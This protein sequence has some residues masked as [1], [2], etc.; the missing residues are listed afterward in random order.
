MQTLSILLSGVAFWALVIGLISPKAFNWMFKG[1]SNR[2]KLGLVFGIPAVVFFVLFFIFSIGTP[3]IATAK[4]PTNKKDITI[5]GTSA[6]DNSKMEVFQNG[7]L[8]KEITADNDGRFSS[9]IELVE[10]SNKIK[11]TSTNEKG[12]TQTSSETEIVLDITPPDLSVEQPQSPTENEKVTIKGKSEKYAKIIVSLGGKE[13]K[14]T[15]VRKDSFEIKNIPLAEGENKFIV[16]AIDQADNY[17]EPKEIVMVYNKPVVKE[18]T[19]TETTNQT[20][21]PPKETAQQTE[22]PKEEAKPTET[23]KVESKTTQQLDIDK[24]NELVK[25]VGS[26]ETTILD[27]SSNYATAQSQPPYQ[28][29]V[30]T[31]LNQLNCSQSKFAL[32]DIN[33]N[34]Y[35]ENQLKDKISRILFTASGSLRSSYGSAD[36]K[37]NWSTSGATNFWSVMLQYK[38]YEDETGALANRTWGVS[39]NGCR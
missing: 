10:G 11:A 7:K 25:K 27:S 17:S 33:K 29:I 26:F 23:P 39:I 16:K 31:S 19:R 28:V 38:S 14:N 3:I 13:V 1:K 6:Y 9:D 22:T 15:S 8:A 30:N 18:E 12:K 37:I 24:I 36:S 20:S 5:T 2:K 32:F 21:E 34:I 35:T 4:S